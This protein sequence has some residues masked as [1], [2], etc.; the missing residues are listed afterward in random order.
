MLITGGSS[1]IGLSTAR[2][3]ASIGHLVYIASR[4]N[5]GEIDGLK[6]LQ[7][8]VTH[9]DSIIAAITEL[10]R[11]EN[12]LDVLI[13]NAGLGFNG[14]VEDVTTEEINALFATN[15][16]GLL[17]VSRAAIPIMREQKAGMIINISSI[18][19]KFG[20]PFRGVY[21]ASKHA[22]EAFSESMSLELKSFGIKVVIVE[23]GDFKTQINENRRV[24]QKAQ[25]DASP[26]RKTFEKIN[27]QVIHEVA[28]AADPI[29][30]GKAIAK[31]IEKKNPKLRY[32]VAA[33]LQKFS[34]TLH[35][36]LPGRT[37]EKMLAKFYNL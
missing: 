33:P 25:T 21:C 5:P 1:G 29:L 35:A 16:T 28:S 32:A 10:V 17:E 3:L 26:Y 18:A 2:H 11:E 24:A 8:D 23:P 13:N 19:G 4:S 20:L 31:I 22:V 9:K 37:Y 7:M 36:L 34:V 15:V 6:W 27:E 14:A 30:M 12:R